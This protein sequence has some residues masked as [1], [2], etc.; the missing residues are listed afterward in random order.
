MCRSGLATE[1][2]QLRIQKLKAELKAITN[3]ED[4]ELRI[5]I[6]YG[7]GVYG[8]GTSTV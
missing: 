5:E 2:Q 1:E 3:D 8:E 7:D 4:K 6:D